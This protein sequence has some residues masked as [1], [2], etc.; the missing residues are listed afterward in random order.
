MRDPGY[1][2][3][4]ASRARRLGQETNVEF[5]PHLARFRRF[6]P[7]RLASVSGL[8]GVYRG[9]PRDEAIGEVRIGA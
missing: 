1:C 4:P 5:L 7:D 8:S 6:N 9:D 3:C 2:R